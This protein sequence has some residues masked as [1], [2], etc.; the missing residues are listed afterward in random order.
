MRLGSV[1]RWELLRTLR[2][3][4]FIIISVLIPAILAVAIFA[5]TSNNPSAAQ[6]LREPP[7]AFVVALVLAVILFMGAFLSGVMALYSV[8][9][10]KQ[11]RVVELVLS[12]VSAQEMMA[13]KVIGL[14]IAG[15]LQVVVWVVVAYVVARQFTTISLVALGPVHWIT[16]PIYFAL[17][18]LLIASI[19]AA[20]G[21]VMKDVQSGGASGLVGLIPYLPIMFMSFIVEN[22]NHVL[23]RI[24]GFIPPF[25]P[26]VMMV[27]IGLG[28]AAW[29][30]IA[31]SIVT[32]AVGVFLTMRFAARIF[33]IGL[34]MYGKA[35][36]AREL[37][38][39]A[40]ARRPR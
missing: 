11:S 26:S 14:G 30:E 9:K 3:K 31:L 12:S 10:E 22:P 17:G 20:L 27:R 16:Y 13:G 1:I 2:S 8:V 38:K 18:F 32:L 19:Y 33:E 37:W 23:V 39:W 4:Q 25:T 5:S 21:A 15:L 40:R 34:L 24:A 29:W 28:S 35:P 7:P 36:S 6:S